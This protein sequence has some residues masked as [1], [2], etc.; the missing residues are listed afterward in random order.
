MIWHAKHGYKNTCASTIQGWALRLKWA[1]LEQ[2]LQKKAKEFCS[3][4]QMP[5]WT[6]EVNAEHSPFFFFF[7]LRTLW[8]IILKCFRHIPLLKLDP[9]HLICPIYRFSGIYSNSSFLFQFIESF[10]LEMTFK[11][12]ELIHW[13][14]CPKISINYSQLYPFMPLLKILFHILIFH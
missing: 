7:F 10:R 13:T 2:W 4:I 11:I 14:L 6:K 3:A 12:I 9:S 5:P 8:I 1:C